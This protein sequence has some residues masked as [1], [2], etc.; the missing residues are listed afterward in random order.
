MTDSPN[1]PI[2]SPNPEIAHSPNCFVPLHPLSARDP[3]IPPAE[4]RLDVRDSEGVHVQRR[5]GARGFGHSRTVGD[6]QP[7]LLLPD[8][9]VIGNVIERD[10]DR[11]GHVTFGK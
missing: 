1:R 8:I 9:D 2:K 7:L 6:E 10:V 3:L 11:A 4:H 5:T